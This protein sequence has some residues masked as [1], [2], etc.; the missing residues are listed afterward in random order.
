MSGDLF[1]SETVSNWMSDPVTVGG[2]ETLTISPGL[3][4]TH[5]NSVVVVA[6]SDPTHLFQGQVLSYNTT[7]GAIEI[8]VTSIQGSATFP[9]DIYTVNLNP[10]NGTEGPRS[11]WP[12]G[13][14]GCNWSNRLHRP[15]RR[16]RPHR[17]NGTH[18]FARPDR[19]YWHVW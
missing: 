8:Y 5:G 10:L 16:N 7:S 14:H 19:P 9:S 18:W 13:S 3:S 2:S 6:S 1:T 4:F 11:N 17:S 12:A 15:D